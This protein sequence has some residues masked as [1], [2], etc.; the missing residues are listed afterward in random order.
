MSY[1]S[2]TFSPPPSHRRLPARPARDHVRSRTASEH[3]PYRFEVTVGQGE[4]TDGIL[5]LFLEIG[6]FAASD[7]GKEITFLHIIA[8]FNLHLRNGP[9]EDRIHLAT[10][11]A[12]KATRP[13]NNNSSFKGVLRTVSTETTCRRLSVNIRP[14]DVCSGIEACLPHEK[15]RGKRK[16]RKRVFLFIFIEIYFKFLSVLLL[17]A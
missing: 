3:I 7:N 2:R 10:C 13:F 6:H 5:L 15:N 8:G 17:L 14:V 1:T 16:S 9:S 11:P 4:P 12:S